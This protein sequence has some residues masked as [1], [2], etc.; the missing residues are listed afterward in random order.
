M[1]AWLC[2]ILSERWLRPALVR[3]GET[4]P[5][6]YQIWYDTTELSLRPNRGPE[7]L[8]AYQLGIITREAAGRELGFPSG[9]IAQP[10]TAPLPTTNV[11]VVDLDGAPG[12]QSRDGA[13][14][15]GGNSDSP[16]TGIHT[17]PSPRGISANPGTVTAAISASP[18]AGWFACA[19][20][21]SRRALTRA[22]QRLL[23]RGGRAARG[24]YRDTP[25][26]QIHTQLPTPPESVDFVLEGA[27]T[28]LAQ[29]AP[30]LVAPVDAYVRG[31]LETGAAHDSENLA[32]HF[33]GETP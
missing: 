14:A 1:L 16:A 20:M 29:V 18:V 13:G 24:Q 28:E 17:S 3:L 11:S 2:D 21:A 22:G 10:G 26:D 5:R 25:A 8:Q 7:A 32:R 31:L 6:A 33:T 19:D 9:D 12:I 15:S 23:S 4:D 30:G 27:Y